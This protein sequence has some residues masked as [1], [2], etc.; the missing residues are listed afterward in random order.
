M[1][2]LYKKCLKYLNST[3]EGDRRAAIKILNNYNLN[4][5]DLDRLTKVNKQN[6]EQENL[7]LKSKNKFKNIFSEY[8][9][10]SKC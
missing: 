1:I 6:T 4:I 7:I 8:S 5:D 10:K 3:D 9:D 2:V